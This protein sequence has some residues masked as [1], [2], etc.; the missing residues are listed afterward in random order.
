[1]AKTKKAKKDSPE[2]NLELLKDTPIVQITEMFEGSEGFYG[3]VYEHSD[4]GFRCE[5][6]IPTGSEQLDAHLDGGFNAGSISLFYGDAESGKTAQGM[7]WGRNWQDT[8]GEK[9]W[10]V[11]YDAEGRLTDKKIRMSGIDKSRLI[12]IKSNAAEIV[13]QSVQDLII[14]NP[15]GYKYFFIVDSLNALTTADER[16]K[17]LSDKEAMAGIARVTSMAFKKVSLPIHVYGHH[18][19]LCSQ[20]RVSNMTG[21]GGGKPSGGKATE[22]YGDLNAKMGQAWEGTSPRLLKDGESVI[23]RYTRVEFKKSY[24]EITG[25]NIDIPIKYDYVGGIWKEA[26]IV[27]MAIAWGIILVKGSWVQA[28]ELLL[29]DEIERAGLDVKDVCKNV[30]GKGPFINYL[31]ENQDITNFI[32][33]YLKTLSA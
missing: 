25:T 29:K 24:N 14:Q 2:N 9:G 33:A 27:D 12:V 18:L 19:Y 7:S 5:D 28:Q 20:V 17:S 13:L 15:Q 31:E 21:R 1:M 16:G 3:S 11:I 30:Q 22:F 23:G 26:E 8:Y 6:K 10:V 4:D 32:K